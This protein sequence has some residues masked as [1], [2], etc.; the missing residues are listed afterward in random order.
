MLS[1]NYLTFQRKTELYLNC[2]YVYHIQQITISICM[3]SCGRMPSTL[4]MTCVRLMATTCSSH[5]GRCFI[6]TSHTVITSSLPIPIPIPPTPPSRQ[7]HCSATNTN[8]ATVTSI[9]QHQHQHRYCH[10]H[11]PKPISLQSPPSVAGVTHPRQT[12]YTK[13][14]NH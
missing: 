2:V 13:P 7:R 9:H 1:H 11:L 10:L 14:V 12:L 8:I 6:R 4:N 5:C 3:P